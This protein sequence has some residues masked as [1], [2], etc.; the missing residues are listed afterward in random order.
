[1][2]LSL[3]FKKSA[4]GH[5]SLPWSRKSPWRELR[6]GKANAAPPSGPDS[7]DLSKSSTMF[8]LAFDVARFRF[9][10]CKA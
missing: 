5:V 6:T 3:R 4:E 8:Q 7:Q 9:R 1:M 2:T 10:C